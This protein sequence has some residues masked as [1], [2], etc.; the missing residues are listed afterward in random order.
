MKVYR[1]ISKV[2]WLISG[3]GS[4]PYA[5][6]IF[7]QEGNVQYMSLLMLG[8]AAVAFDGIVFPFYLLRGEVTLHKRAASVGFNLVVAAFWIYFSGGAGSF[9]FPHL[10][11]LPIITANFYGELSDAVIASIIASVLAV[12][13][14]FLDKGM[15]WGLMIS[16]IGPEIISF[17]LVGVLLGYL[18][19]AEK[20]ERI[21]KQRMTEQL[22]EAY[23][24]LSSSHEQ[25]QAYTEII[26]EL[27]LEME[28]LAVTD[29]LTELYNYRYF[30]LCLEK[31]LELCK[32]GSMALLMLDIDHFKEV[33]DDFGHQSGNKVLV[34]ISSLIRQKVR[35]QDI[36]VRYGGEEFSIILPGIDRDA[37]VMV[38]ERIRESIQ[39]TPVV[40][41]QGG[42]VQVTVSIGV[43]LYPGRAN[44]KSDLISQ[45]D[46]ALY[47]A[48]E[49]G[50]N[51]V[52]V[53]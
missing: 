34:E 12:A 5:L 27:N 51:R 2:L 6:F 1:D 22:Q 26:Q 44:T 38:A 28:R 24:R 20:H 35:D 9:A 40:S 45:A 17:L 49:E 41:E 18:V 19:K 43:A 33:N 14:F 46:S 48:K 15:Q 39:N 4:I 8:V 42:M 52:C 16:A 7:V 32:T 50:R 25:L 31:E 21:T 10:F 3:I 23:K 53:F 37:A 29:E 36:V 13:I 47:R 30:H 11:F